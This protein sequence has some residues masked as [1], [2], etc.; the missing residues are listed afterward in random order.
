MEDE[1]A[2][3]DLLKNYIARL[4]SLDLIGV[5]NNALE[6]LAML[7]QHPVDILFCDIKMPHLNGLDFIKTLRS[8]PAVVL[9]TA[10]SEYALESYELDVRDYLLKPFPFERFVKAVNKCVSYAAV[11]HTL[12]VAIHKNNEAGLLTPK[13]ENHE[14]YPV[15]SFIEKGKLVALPHK[16][17]LYGEGYGNYVKIHTTR[18]T[19]LFDSSLIALEKNLPES[20]F[21]RI[22]KSYLIALHYAHS[23][24][25]ETVK[26]AENVLPVGRKFALLLADKMSSYHQRSQ[27]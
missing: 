17:I 22:H 12:D 6:G 10:F 23:L 26:V 5:C 1:V 13:S 20:E 11:P 9:T 3:Q 18:R 2:A 7:H 16:D 27:S 14:I 24:S 19:Y 4:P 21:I 8:S 15:L 25:Q